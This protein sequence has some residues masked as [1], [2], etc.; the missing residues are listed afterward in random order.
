M[1]MN[2][3]GGDVRTMGQKEKVGDIKPRPSGTV[4]GRL[5]KITPIMNLNEMTT[6]VKGRNTLP[7]PTRGNVILY[8]KRERF[9][10]QLDHT[11]RYAANRLRL[12]VC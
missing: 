10:N 8:Q 5:Q 11:Y 9:I 6:G 4:V 1:T 3:K 12:R 2:T 7:L